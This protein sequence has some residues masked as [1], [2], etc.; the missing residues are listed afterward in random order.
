MQD[1]GTAIQNAAANVRMLLTQAAAKAWNVAAKAITTTGDGRLRSPDGRVT[2]YGEL[3]AKLSLHVEAI[4]NAPRRDPPSFRTIGTNMRR[5]DI[6]AKL[7]GGP[8]YVHDMR[9]PGM[10]HARVVRG[11]SD[12]T[13]FQP[14]DV[15]KVEAL[16]GIVKVVQQGA[17]TAVV[18]EREWTAITA[19]RRFQDAKFVRKAPPLPDNGVVATLKRL[20][21]QEIVVL[22]THGA[23]APAVRS[24]KARYTRPWLAHGSI[25]PSCALA[26]FRDG[27]MTV[28]THSQGVF[29]LRRA[30]AE[31]VGLPLD[32]VSAIHTE[33]AGCYGHNGADDV[34]ADA[35]LIAKALPGRPIRLQWM[36]E[37][38]F[39]WE[40]LGPGMVTELEAWLDADNRI[41]SWRH[42]VWSNPH[43]TRPVGAGSVLAGAEVVPSFPAPEPTPIPMPEGDGSR[44]SNPLY[45]LP[46]MY[47]LFHFLKDMPLRTSALR[48][49][50]AHLNV[51]SIEC[52]FDELAKV[53][54]V[55]P[56]AMRLAHMK[57][58]RARV[59][60][61]TAADRFAWATRAKGDGR[62]GCGM[63]FARYKNLGAYCAVAMEIEVERETGR[64]AVR[65]AVA[66]VD[67]GQTVNPDG[68]RNQIEGGIVQS[69]SWTSREAVTF[70]S[71]HRT[72]FDWSSYPILRFPD[73][74]DAVEVRIVDRPGLPFLGTGEAA[75]GPTAAALA[76]A[77]ADATGVRLRDMPLSPELVKTAIDAI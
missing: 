24:V 68:V 1:S 5:V 19:L 45:A 23:A 11:P 7:T 18:A 72:S 15:A 75:Q 9:M 33:G 6:L 22:D 76:N 54:G 66:A 25:G 65:R 29:N 35:A 36:R 3:A 37:Q 20:R 32:K 56:L 4:P 71:A 70:D 42:E 69:L 40:P 74:P 51:F 47:V 10:L 48:S 58:E 38:E 77:L 63:A 16:P 34:G 49:L 21:S 2:T 13:L 27:V 31:L 57:D 73:V 44:N 59:V 12:G 17:F 64:I 28:W 43:N 52:M 14:I 53:G 41:V 60:I 39:G 55:D 26:L 62:R 46:N 67:C 61:Q 50:G 8:A 30:V